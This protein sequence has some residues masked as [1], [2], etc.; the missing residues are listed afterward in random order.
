MSIFSRLPFT[1]W[2][3]KPQAAQPEISAA[4]LERFLDL[5]RP[6]D[7]AAQLRQLL[8][9]V[10]LFASTSPEEI[11]E[12]AR[13]RWDLHPDKTAELLR[14]EVEFGFR[15]YSINGVLAD[16]GASRV[17]IDKARELFHD[18]SR[19]DIDPGRLA[20]A[21][22]GDAPAVTGGG[23]PETQREPEAQREPETHREPEARRENQVQKADESAGEHR[24]PE[25]DSAEDHKEESGL[26]QAATTKPDPSTAKNKDELLALLRAFR[27]WK[28]RVSYRKMESA[29]GRR[30][31]HSTLA[32]V[33]K[34]PHLPS[35]DLVLAFIEGCG[36][37]AEDLAAWEAAWRRIAMSDPGNGPGCC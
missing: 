16:C 36:G 26:A 13:R 19:R 27:I 34:R 32:E 5:S 25:D 29:I 18:F 33:P 37:D 8:L 9:L 14:G 35:L 11:T 15:W 12:N 24:E 31:V 7:P 1:L 2:P 30:Y 20:R 3:R 4:R 28:G 22:E 17:F 21:Q 6:G 10:F 23:E